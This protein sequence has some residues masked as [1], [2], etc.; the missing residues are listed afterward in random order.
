MQDPACAFITNKLKE[1]YRKM[2]TGDT[3]GMVEEQ[4]QNS[5]PFNLNARKGKASLTIISPFG[6]VL[7]VNNSENSRKMGPTSLG[8]PSIE[9][10]PSPV[11][12][13]SEGGSPPQ[14]LSPSKGG[15]ERPDMRRTS[16]NLAKLVDY[17][18]EMEFNMETRGKDV[19]FMLEGKGICLDGVNM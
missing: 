5:Y 8:V 12:A 19:N 11:Q 15:E 4:K 9:N 16:S 6:S 3:E 1:K 14:I 18:D 7:A 10:S 17:D 13:K 2:T